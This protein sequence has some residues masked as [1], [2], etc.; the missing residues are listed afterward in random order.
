LPT[1]PPAVALKGANVLVANDGT[2]KLADFGASKSVG[3]KSLTAT[4]IKGTPM[5]MAPEVIKQQQ[6]VTGWKKADIWSVGCT[7]IEM[8][9]GRPPWSQYSNP[10]TAMYHIA[11]EDE[12][13]TIPDVL[14]AQGEQFLLAALRRDPDVR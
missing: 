2:V 5:W 12:I 6:T 10:V 8:V 1:H 14:S 13:P 7:V 11:C 3:H 4:G 9:T